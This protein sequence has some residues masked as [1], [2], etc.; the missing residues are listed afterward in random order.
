MALKSPLA[1]GC[2]KPVAYFNT[3]DA[4]LNP[5]LDDKLYRDITVLRRC[6]RGVNNLENRSAG[7]EQQT[8][9]WKQMVDFCVAER[10]VMRGKST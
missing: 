4:K 8:M 6:L 3:N 5:S 2:S 10:L 7:N 1:L 9:S